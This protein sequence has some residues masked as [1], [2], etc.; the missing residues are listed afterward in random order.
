MTE[1]VILALNAGSSSIK[2]GL[3]E[4]AAAGARRIGRAQVDLRAVPVVLMLDVDGRR[5]A[6][7]LDCEVTESL[8]EVVNAVLAVLQAHN[9]LR[10]LRFA[11]HRV[12]HGGTRFR[13][14]VCIDDAV[15]AELE[16][17]TPLAPLH[18]PHCLRLVRAMGRLRPDLPQT[19]SFD[20]AFHHTQDPLVRRFA[21]PRELHQQGVQRYGFHGLSYAWIARVL[22]ERHPG[23]APGRVVAAHLGSGARLCALSAGRSVDS[24][25]GFS[26]LDG[27][28]MATRCGAIDP[29]VLLYLLQS[30]MSLK[31]LEDLL[32][33]RSGLL[34]LSGASADVRVLRSRDD[35]ASREALQLL[36][37]RCAGEAARLAATM[38]GLDAVIFTAG[39]GEHDAVLRSDIAARLGWLGAAVDDSANAADAEIISSRHSR[40]HLLVIPTDEEQIIADEAARLVEPRT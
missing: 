5:E 15:L 2:L 27:I 36:A 19:A 22:A 12:V 9:A 38:G 31:D 8:E 17:L 32:Y 35:R 1:H 7:T 20:T 18:Q 4:I 39:I 34:G 30:G 28:P 21:I 14:A 23:V 26:T 11:A 25:M 29:G 37:M 16:A 40:V 13:G 6:C 3:Y 24:S 10:G 33:H